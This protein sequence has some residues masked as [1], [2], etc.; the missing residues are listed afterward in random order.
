MTRKALLFLFGIL[1][2]NISLSQDIMTLNDGTK[3]QCEVISLKLRFIEYKLADSLESPI[4][5]IKKSNV[6][7]IEYSSGRVDDLSHFAV[8]ESHRN[9]LGIGAGYNVVIFDGS[10][11]MRVSTPFSDTKVDYEFSS[12]PSFS[13]GLQ[14]EVGL[15]KRKSLAVYWGLASYIVNYETEII[16]SEEDLFGEFVVINTETES[17]S[18]TYA[19]I[20][21][22]IRFYKHDLIPSLSTSIYGD[23][24]GVANVVLS[25]DLASTL[26][27]NS[28]FAGNI[29]V[30]TRTLVSEDHVALFTKFGL[31]IPFASGI[32]NNAY[33]WDFNINL[34]VSIGL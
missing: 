13:F 8:K 18:H 23:L 19:S 10:Y 24:G 1:L 17:N 7:R 11:T 22:G 5:T 14:G 29:G 32:E 15:N 9:Y 16:T 2:S 12:S 3:I 28:F 6:S 33:I 21:L 34:G 25:S 4:Y 27:A 26:E 31:N 20:P 30:G